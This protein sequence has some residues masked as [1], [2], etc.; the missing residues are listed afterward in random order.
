VPHRGVEPGT[1][2]AGRYRVEDL[3]AESA[4]A[5]QW[6]AFDEVLARSVS[7][8]VLGADDPRADALL[9]AARRS[10]VVPDSRFVHVLDA[11][12]EN[13]IVFVVRE[14][15]P[16]EPLD[17]TLAHGPLAHRRAVW[18][19]GQCA[20]ALAAAHDL[21]IPH[22]CLKP[23]NVWITA[24]GGVKIAGL[25][26]DAALRGVSSPDPAAE[27]VRGLGRLLYACLVARWPAAEAVGLPPAPT[28]NGRLLRPRQVRAGIP[29]PLDSVC[30]A[31]LSEPGGGGEAAAAAQV[32]ESARA[33]AV[34]LDDVLTALDTPAAPE[35]LS[36]R[37]APALLGAGWGRQEEETTAALPAPGPPQPSSP[38]P[39]AEPASSAT[40]PVP[41]IASPLPRTGSSPRAP[42]KRRGS[43][44]LL[45]LAVAVLV[46]GAALLA[47]Q[48]G[49]SAGTPDDDSA[50]PATT[51]GGPDS[52]PA[53]SLERIGIAGVIDFD[54]VADAGSGEENP[55]LAPLA[56]DGDPQTA[57][58]TLVYKGNPQLGGLKPGVGLVVDLGAPETVAEVK[59]R[60]LGVGTNVQLRAAPE[61]AQTVPT[62]ADGFDVVARAPSAGA[63]VALRSDQ[64]VT[65]RFLL[66]YLTSL[67]QVGPGDYQGSVAEITVRG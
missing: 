32:P 38:P 10:S 5:H 33:V 9:E 30:V 26:T 19:V 56:I 29:R 46:A 66:V 57:W 27:D 59:L 13:G 22:L 15:V 1:V 2:L 20:A 21:G 36:G 11:A 42:T 14:W 7:V 35:P 55:N 24:T 52:S 6:R 23:A 50:A 43:R 44:M 47:Y 67:P 28:E 37:A 64:P 62:S 16:G 8:E 41:V 48:L 3:R 63:T 51:S 18:I 61:T 60:L 53:A 25:A 12:E 65:S 4:G 40:Q 39:H 17:A 54:P 58:S 34:A 49:R 45:W 31:L